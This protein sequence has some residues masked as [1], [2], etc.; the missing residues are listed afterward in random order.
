MAR[1]PTNRNVS[2]YHC[3]AT[4]EVPGEALSSNCPSCHKKVAIQDLVLKKNRSQLMMR[5]QVQTCGRIVVPKGATLIADLVEAQAGIE[6]KG[7]LEARLVVSGRDTIIGKKAHWR[8]DLKS[9]T[10]KVED[11]ATI[12]PSY[13]E[14]TG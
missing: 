9:Q 3:R 2:C 13:F 12:L 7:K 10:L 6:V 8:A 1:T 11:Q 14:V 5:D 4:F